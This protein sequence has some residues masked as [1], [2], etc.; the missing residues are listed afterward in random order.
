MTAEEALILLDTLLIRSTLSDIQELVFCY[1]WNGKKYTEIAHELNYNPEHIKY[2]GYKLWSLL[3]SALGEKVTKSN[4]RSVLRRRL[5]KIMLSA[6]EQDLDLAESDGITRLLETVTSSLEPVRQLES[7]DAHKYRQDWGDASEVSSFYDR[8]LEQEQLERWITVDQCRLIVMLGMGGVGKTTLTIRVARHLQNQFEF[9]FWRSLRNAPLPSHT[10]TE[11]LL[12]LGHQPDNIP[13]TV[14][15]MI[16]GVLNYLRLHRCLISLDNFETVLQSGDLSGRYRDNYE[17]YGQLLRQVGEISHQSLLLVTSREYPV[18]IVEKSGDALPIRTLQLAGV[19]LTAAKAI[20]ADKGV[21]VGSDEDWQTLVDHFGGNPL[22]F[23]LAAPLIK[24]FSQGDISAGV[25]LIRQGLFAF[26][27]IRDALA[28]QFNRLSD[29]EKAVMFWLA[30]NREAATL[31]TL[32]LDFWPQDAQ[33]DLLQALVSLHRRSLIESTPD[34]FVQQPAVMEFVT[35]TLIEQVVADILA[36]SPQSLMSHCLIKA[37]AGDYTRDTQTHFILKP[38]AEKLLNTLKTKRNLELKLNRIVAKIRSSYTK[39]VT[40]YAA[41][42]IINLLNLVQCNLSGYDFSDLLIWQAY[43]PNIY[44]HHVNFAQADLSRSVFAETLNSVWSVAF[45]PTG[46][47]LATG[48]INCEI[49]LWQVQEGKQQWIGRG[50]N[51]WVTGIAFS[52]DGQILASCSG[53]NTVK[54]WTVAT[55]QCFRTLQ[56]HEGW[57]LAVAFSPDGQTLASCGADHTVR[58]WDIATNQ[59]IQVFRHHSAWVRS[60]AFSPFGSRLASASED[61]TI[62][63][64]DMATG[65]HVMTLQGHRDRVHSVV[66]SPDGQRLASGSTDQTIKL[67]DVA[68]GE[69]LQTLW[70]HTSQIQSVTFNPTGT[71]LASGSDD[72]TIRLWDAQTG[73][74]L[75]TLQGQSSLVR[76]VTFSP[77]GKTLVSVG[78][79]RKIKFWDPTT[80]RCLRTWQGQDKS[81]WSVAC[82]PDHQR[83]VTGNDDHTLNLWDVSQ[84]K[85]LQTLRGHQNWVWSVAFSP[86]GTRLASASMDHTVKLWD[87]E[88]GQCLKTLTEHM[89]YVHAAQFSPD[90]K[91]LASGGD[92]LTIKLWDATLGRCLKTLQ[93]HGGRIWSLAFSPTGLHLASGSEDHMVKLWDIN[94][95]ECLQTLEGHTNRIRAVAFHPQGKMLAS[96]SDDLTVKLWDVESGNCTATLQVSR[97]QVLAIA[98]SPDGN[99]L[100]TSGGDTPILKLWNLQTYQCDLELQGHTGYVY[101]L[102]YTSD[103]QQIIS[104][105]RDEQIRVWNAQTGDCLHILQSPRLYENLNIRDVTGL[106]EAQRETLLALGAVER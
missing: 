34:G 37:Q 80:G 75:K 7:H 89:S 67:W 78:L 22:V 69:C 62:A 68:T 13:S 86:D 55:G 99:T 92:D 44:L 81:I 14:E 8:T 97:D 45:S 87:V 61:H 33:G 28:R 84:E 1:C 39:T 56:D 29:T 83:I 77:D 53:D 24:D 63:L 11:L 6:A 48:D 64:W 17:G 105:G 4:I 94:Q 73:Q 59:C 38:I 36:E 85:C 42:N 3:S 10:L 70:S 60:V 91:V 12:F 5:Q 35:D 100:V 65:Q 95:G 98:F 40:G 32:Q 102:L 51:S 19:D 15:G 20:F 79:D 9:V 46:Q 106:T 26:S 2:V 30:I 93:G 31:Q 103:G 82:S 21:F 25:N 50:H 76:A 47:W 101:G 43:L 52:P 90:G 71:L 23:K 16:A 49:R 74:R 57:V 41:G 96:G 66:F 54:L 72:Q 27:D 18:G 104:G 58:L 88:T